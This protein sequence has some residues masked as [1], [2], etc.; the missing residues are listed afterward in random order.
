MG[1]RGGA[2]ILIYKTRSDGLLKKDLLI[3]FRE[4]VSWE[5]GREGEI[6][7]RLPTEQEA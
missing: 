5:R 1:K 7:S 4:N 3:D 2:S 6:L